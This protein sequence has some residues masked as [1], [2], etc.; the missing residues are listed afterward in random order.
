[1]GDTAALRTRMV[2]NQLRTFDVTDHRVQDA[3][4][5]VLREHYVPADQ[6]AI[7][8]SD[9]AIPIARDHLGR[10]AR[11]M[12][13]PQV[14]GRMLQAAQVSEDDVV[15]VVGAGL[16]YTTAVIGLLAGSVIALECDAS[17]AEKASTTLEADDVTNAV[18]VTGDL[19]DGY[20]SEAPYDVVFV[21]GAIEVPPTTL[22]DQVKDG[23]RLI[24]IEGEGLA[25][26]A[27]L[28]ERASTGLSSRTLFNA[29]A[30]VLPGFVKTPDFVF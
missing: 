27:K 30:S 14:L 1:M 10:P 21:D 25:G 24:A 5:E 9:E 2:N 18:V 29:A 26:R 11:T 20:A 17:L 6:K 4:L 22:L 12:T 28:Y 19:E 3:M 23:G 7:A 16:G 8:Y 13:R 15:L